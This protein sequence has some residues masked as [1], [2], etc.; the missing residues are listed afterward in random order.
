MTLL[1]RPEG[2][3]PDDLALSRRALPAVL[4]AGYAA[5]A[6]SAA[7][8]P[9]ITDE[10]GLIT[11]TLSLPSGDFALPAYV[12]RPRGAGRRAAVLVVSEVF[13][14]HAYIQDVCRRF[15]KLG[16]VAIAPAFFVRAGDP[17]PLTDMKAVMA[18][19][20]KASDPQVLG[21][22]G[23]TLT[24]LKRQPFVDAHRLAITGFCWGGGVTWL[25]CE[26]FSDF[27]AGVA[28]Y[29]RMVASSAVADPARLWPVARVAQLKAP[30]LGIYGGKDPL[31]DS[32]PAMRAALAA[33][34]KTDSEIIVYPQA[35]HGFH[36]DYR[37]TYDAAAAQDGWKRLLA[38]FRAHGAAP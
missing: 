24:W 27:K 33:A 3:Y 8:E 6:L 34:G 30:V 7:A 20:A 32:V 36:A 5:A 21:D 19:V 37:A 31:S 29:G 35:A 13:G 2:V 15:A 17:A 38:F 25:A 26:E 18:I 22:V 4:F 10:A 16:Y 23:A 1:T 11:Q 12:A 9:I 28:W 14:L